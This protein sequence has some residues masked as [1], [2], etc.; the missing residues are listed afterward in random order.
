M[1]SRIWRRTLPVVL[2][3][4]LAL[5][6]AASFAGA[7]GWDTGLPQDHGRTIGLFIKAWE[8]IVGIWEKAGAGLDPHGNRGDGGSPT[9][10]NSATTNTEAGG[11]IDPNG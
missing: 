3:G 2:A 11:S 7:L 6:P 4:L 1:F 5:L 8:T 9:D 10:P